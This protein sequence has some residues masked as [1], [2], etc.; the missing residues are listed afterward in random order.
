MAQQDCVG[1]DALDQ[2]RRELSADHKLLLSRVDRNFRWHIGMLI[3]V[4]SGMI[5]TLAVVVTLVDD[6]IDEIRSEH[7]EH[8]QHSAKWTNEIKH[9]T[10]KIT[11]C[12]G[13]E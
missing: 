1:H 5:S 10:E 12:C 4:F 2:V 8:L 6:A 7:I 3:T 9:N 11:S 13:E